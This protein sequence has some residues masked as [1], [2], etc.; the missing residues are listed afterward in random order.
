[1][2][3]IINQ[4]WFK[5]YPEVGPVLEAPGAQF[6]CQYYGRNTSDENAEEQLREKREILARVPESA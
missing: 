3:K 6:P 2:N 5:M 1:M 4:R